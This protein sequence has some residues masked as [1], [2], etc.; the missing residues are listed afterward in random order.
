L[1]VVRE[2]NAEDGELRNNRAIDSMW[3]INEFERHGKERL[4]VS[5]GSWDAK[6]EIEIENRFEK[7]E[8]KMKLRRNCASSLSKLR[9]SII[10]EIFTS[11]ISHVKW[12]MDDPTRSILQCI[13]EG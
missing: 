1:K 6:F 10:V 5:E 12:P 11:V 9:G 8:T 7:V 3:R 13:H 2:T 4:G